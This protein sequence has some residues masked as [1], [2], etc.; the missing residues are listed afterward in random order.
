MQSDDN[1]DFFKKKLLEEIDQ[2]SNYDSMTERSFIMENNI[3]NDFNNSRAWLEFMEGNKQRDIMIQEIEDQLT[4]IKKINQ[5]VGVIQIDNGFGEVIEVQLKNQLDQQKLEEIRNKAKAEILEIKNIEQEE[6]I[7]SQIFEQKQFNKESVIVNDQK[8]NQRIENMNQQR[9]QL[10]MEMEDQFSQQLRLHFYK[11]ETKQRLFTLPNQFPSIQLIQIQNTPQI[12][13][14]QPILFPIVRIPQILPLT[15][16]NLAPKNSKAIVW[17]KFQKKKKQ[18]QSESFK[19]NEEIQQNIIIKIDLSYK[20]TIILAEHQKKMDQLKLYQSPNDIAQLKINSIMNHAVKKSQ[21]IKFKYDYIPYCY[22]Y[23]D[24]PQTGKQ[25]EDK[26]Y[27]IDSFLKV[28]YENQIS[29]NSTKIEIKLEIISDFAGIDLFQNL[30]I[31]TL[32]SNKINSCQFIA[33][34]K[35]LVSLNLSQN[36]IINYEEIGNLPNLRILILEMN[37]ITQVSKLK[38]CKY[39][40]VY[41]LG[42]NKIQELNNLDNLIYLKHLVA[43]K[44]LIKTI[45]IEN[46]Y[47][48]EHLD[49]GSNQLNFL[50]NQSVFNNNLCL[51][52]LIL[53]K[54]NLDSLPQLNLPLLQELYINKN[55]LETLNGL[56]YLPNLL[57]LEAQDNQIQ[58]CLDIPEQ[59][60]YLPSIKT[61]KLQ[62]NQIQSFGT[63]L[64]LIQFSPLL[65]SIQFEENPFLYQIN[66]DVRLVYT[67]LLL[68]NHKQLKVLN[69]E[70]INH[71]QQSF[72]EQKFSG[73]FDLINITIDDGQIHKLILQISYSIENLQSLINLLTPNNILE[74]TQSQIKNFQ[75]IHFYVNQIWKKFQ[76]NSIIIYLTKTQVIKNF[77]YRWIY[78]YRKRRLFFQ[79]NIRKIVYL[80][81]YYRGHITRRDPKL[82]QFV[83]SRQKKQKSQYAIKIQKLFRGFRVRKRMR[84]L[85][86]IQFDDPDLME[87]GYVDENMFDGDMQKDYQLQIPKNVDI[88]KLMEQQKVI[89]PIPKIIQ[90]NN[91]F[92]DQQVQKNDSKFRITT[93]SGPKSM[94][95]SNYSDK[96]STLPKV[97]QRKADV[98]K[99]MENWGFKDQAV[100]KTLAFKMEKERARKMKKKILTPEERLQKFKQNIK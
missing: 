98:D 75:I 76:K 53:Y 14:F 89:A 48:L 31:L 54:N 43:F 37:K 49:L 73:F 83:K 5:A 9:E 20:P 50:P 10:E 96:S 100:A 80:Q 64:Q 38:Q 2:L 24:F 30:K 7:Q 99:I 13:I 41:N 92:Q 51:R 15:D 16:E 70:E 40:E 60:S 3:P 22:P 85:N 79:N 28:C 65:Q 72:I 1:E 17:Q 59:I 58:N 46:N 12:E 91:F 74:S 97:N 90:H 36:E 19:Q 68:R 33:N 84:Q 4:E 55:K 34:L 93:Q 94:Q 23:A 87:M 57:L 88:I 81:A 44:N 71:Q 47:Y 26:N 82:I 56:V 61:I 95:T 25:L 67:Y 66:E 21:S 39:L 52:K 63:I 42:G 78:K 62:N 69:Q 45:D 77:I 32:S 8:Q 6:Y 35:Q 11:Q 27:S 18:I 86:N 29:V